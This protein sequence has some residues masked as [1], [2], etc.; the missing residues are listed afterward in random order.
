MRIL[1]VLTSDDAARRGVALMVAAAGWSVLDVAIHLVMDEVDPVRVAG[2]L[3]I[4]AAA[5]S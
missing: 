3:V 4:V 2:N 1:S 5:L